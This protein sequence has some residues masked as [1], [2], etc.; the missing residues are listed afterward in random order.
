MQCIWGVFEYI[1]NLNEY[2]NFKFEIMN[3]A[4]QP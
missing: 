2:F 4:I 1:E 3:F